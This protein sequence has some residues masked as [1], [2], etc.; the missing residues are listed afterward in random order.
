MAARTLAKDP[1]GCP[2]CSEL[3]RIEKE[4]KREF[5]PYLKMLVEDK[6]N[7]GYLSLLDD[8]PIEHRA[9]FICSEGHVRYCSLKELQKKNG[10]LTCYTIAYR[11][12]NLADP[13]YSDLHG[14]FV[15]APGYPR[16]E[17]EDIPA[18]S[19]TIVV[20]WR[21][22]KDATHEWLAYPFRRTSDNRGCPYCGNQRLAKDQSLAHKFPKIA[23]EFDPN[24]NLS[25][26]TGLPISPDSI[27]PA[28]RKRYFFVCMKGHEQYKM[29]PKARTESGAGCPLCEVLP[30]SIAVVRPDLASQW[31]VK[32]NKKLC[33]TLSP[34]LS[35]IH[36]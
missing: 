17:L 27:R 1:Q 18:G 24:L 14:E 10:C 11:G 16:F 35:L 5:A 6:R 12:R 29:S 33:P 34:E 36:I 20:L 2:R 32:K 28:D 30:K 23:R 13:L 7:A 9:H 3:W 15:A 4:N 22:A 25:P 26:K 31:H 19:G 21:C 8:F